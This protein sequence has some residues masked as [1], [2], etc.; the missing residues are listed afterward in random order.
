MN[1]FSAPGGYVE[2]L[3]L[4]GQHLW[5]IDFDSHQIHKVDPETGDFLH[6]ID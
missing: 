2:G 1:S 4:D 3:A 5:M 6:T